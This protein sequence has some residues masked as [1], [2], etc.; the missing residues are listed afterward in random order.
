MYKFRHEKLIILL[1]MIVL[2]SSCESPDAPV[3]EFEIWTITPEDEAIIDK[4]EV[5]LVWDYSIIGYKLTGLQA[6][7]GTQE[8]IKG[9]G[10]Y[11]KNTTIHVDSLEP[12]TKYYWYIKGYY[13]KDGHST[14]IVSNYSTFTTADSL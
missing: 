13:I 7:L 10:P 6:Q 3:Q 14:I 12:A 5:E 11:S 2:C 8:D 4:P 9:V 1:C